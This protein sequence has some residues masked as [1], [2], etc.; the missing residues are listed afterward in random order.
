MK[1]NKRTAL[2]AVGAVVALTIIVLLV[3]QCHTEGEDTTAQDNQTTRVTPLNI[4]ILLDLSDRLVAKGTNDNVSQME[5]DTAII[6]YVQR[7]FI[8][9]QFKNQLQTNDRIQVLMYPNPNTPQIVQLQKRLIADLKLEGNKAQAIK[10]NK[11]IMKDMPQVWTE[12]LE[13]IY[14]TTISDK[15][16]IGSDVWGFF[17]VSAKMQCVKSGYRNVLII[18]TDGYLYHK[19]TWQ[20]TAPNEFTGISPLTVSTQTAITPVDND[21][22]G[23]EVLF[24]EINPKKHSDFG[25]IRKL[26]TNWCTSMNIPHVEV[27][28][29]DLPDLTH[30]AMD[31]FLAP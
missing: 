3:R 2:I 18:L 10:S 31:N 28:P 4:S 13:T 29:T 20:K 17:D 9:R 23:L 12:S 30:S 1:T 6:G 27:V 15:H 19:D 21:L 16:W 5:K 22:N 26:L 25:K 11:E 14:N 8:K 7:W 24:M